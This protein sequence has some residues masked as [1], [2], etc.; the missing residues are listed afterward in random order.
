MTKVKPFKAV[1]PETQYVSR[2][3]CPPYDV[4][5]EKEARDMVKKEPLSFMQVIRPEAAYKEGEEFS[6]EEAY[7]K[8][9]E[10][11]NENVKKGIFVEE[12]KPCFYIY[13]Q[14]ASGRIQ[15]GLVACFGADD[16]M[17]GRIKQH[18]AT[19]KNKEEDRICHINACSANTGLVYLAYRNAPALKSLVKKAAHGEAIYDFTSSD[20]VRHVV[21]RVSDPDLISAIEKAAGGIDSF[22]IADGHHRAASA[23]AVCRKKREENPSY[24][25]EEDFNYFMAVAFPSEEL[26]IMPYYRVVK[27]L[28]GLSREE[29]LGRVS[30][31]FEV[32]EVSSDFTRKEKEKH[33]DHPVRKNEI[34]MYLDEKWYCLKAKEEILKSDPV[35]ILDVSLLQENVLSPILGIEDP[36]VDER[37]D[38]VGGIRGMEELERR[39]HEDMRLAFALYPTSMEELMAV[40]DAGLYMPPKSTWFEPKLESGLFVHRI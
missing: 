20:R 12:E 7:K 13:R 11:I 30:E 19:R 16:Y 6:R 26:F 24:S 2:V 29:F 17:E 31:K 22:Y 4:V 34:A 23:V 33:A 18:E 38:F 5:S 27:D 25:G 39:C 28:N 1:R 10:L 15:T 40:A 3:A 32:S 9:G 8:A 35:G 21:W 36:R 37:I 14:I